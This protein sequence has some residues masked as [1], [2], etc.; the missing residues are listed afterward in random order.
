MH[1]KAVRRF[2]WFI[3]QNAADFGLETDVPMV[4]P[5][6]EFDLWDDPFGE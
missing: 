4:V 6:A 2:S 1:R 3:G 5:H